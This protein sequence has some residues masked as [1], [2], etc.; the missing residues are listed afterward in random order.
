LVS[1]PV[2]SMILH[3]A[4]FAC[5]AGAC[6]APTQA[7]RARLTCNNWLVPKAHA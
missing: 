6:M 2:E 1:D 4:A 3:G 5:V 7:I